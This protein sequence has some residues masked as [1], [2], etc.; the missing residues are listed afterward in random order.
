MTATYEAD[1]E[2]VPVALRVAAGYTR[3]S[4]KKSDKSEASPKTQDEAT[5]KKAR[6]RGCKF[7]GHYRD[8]GVSGYD[9]GAKRK[10]FERLLND[11]RDRKIDEI[12][13]FNVTRFSRR[14]P[15]DAIPVVLELFSLGVT[16]TSVSEG[17]F[18]P[19]NTMELIML[20]MRLDAAHQDSKNKS[21]AI[22]GAK[23]LAKQFGGWT[24]G[25]LPYG[26]ESY[27]KSETRVVDGQEA[28]ITIRLLRPVPRNS[29]GTDQ[30]SVA[31]R[32]VDRIFEFKD[33]PWG[34]KK[35]AHPASV[36]AIVAWLNVNG[37]LT[38]N[39]GAWRSPT[40]KRVLT[41]PRLAGFAADPVYY[42]APDGTQSRTISGYK[43]LR[44]PDTGE[45]I[46]IGEALIPPD[47]WFELQEWLS[48]RELGSAKSASSEYLLTAMGVLKCECGHPLTGSP[49]IY[50]CSRAAGVV[51]PGQH[52]GGVTINQKELDEY[53]ARCIM[54]VLM[55]AEDD[56]ETLE[57][58]KEATRRLAKIQERPET[59]S[60]RNALVGERAEVNAGIHRLYDDRQS[61]VFEGP[62]G[63]ARFLQEKELLEGRLEMIERR[64]TEV[65][66]LERP[67][68][69]IEEWTYTE[70][71]DGD[72][73]G[74]GSWWAKAKVPDRR[75]LV[76]L[77]V[78]EVRVS[79][80]AGRGGSNRAC[81]AED[82]VS[83]HMARPQREGAEFTDVA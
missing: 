73:I 30:A 15:K 7:V 39:G 42:K 66:G 17:S 23:R 67:A 72:P 60:E 27:A 56:P 69:P 68:L 70:D 62:I 64:M 22:S 31:L 10:N 16:I 25:A 37:V 2:R 75:T 12:I 63:R 41:D 11:C 83:I 48:G 54:A 46:R 51:V 61:G 55:T 20:I 26:M 45:P 40:A 79:K 77:F 35:N 19:D 52:V 1:Q 65:G 13:V 38:Q 6:E 9:A 44:D 57:I 18:S 8:I 33:K 82:R 21:E 76:G 49:R 78:D 28:T 29:D 74:E 5:R 50:K 43:I 58:L 24:G 80:A 4:K 32:M 47:R 36:G 53:V 14:E 59:R 71:P 3:Q 81:K 34:G